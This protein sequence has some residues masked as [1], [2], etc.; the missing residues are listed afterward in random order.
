[1][2]APGVLLAELFGLGHDASLGLAVEL[3][4]THWRS[5]G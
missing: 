2:R 4:P 3:G 5:G 1:M